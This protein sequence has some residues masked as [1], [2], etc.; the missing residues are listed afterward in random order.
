MNPDV[1][2][3]YRTRW[4]QIVLSPY[5]PYTIRT[6]WSNPTRAIKRIH[7]DVAHET[8]HS[9]ANQLGFDL[10]EWSKANKYFAANP[11]G[12]LYDDLTYAFDSRNHRWKRSPE[13]FLAE[14]SYAQ[15]MLGVKPGF[16]FS[17]WPLDKQKKTINYLSNRFDFTP[18]DTEYFLHKFSQL[19][20]KHGGKI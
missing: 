12:V 15:N 6:A 8:L 3:R 16:G 18:E 4:N 14:M 9:V 2:A 5:N 13:E 20:F 17:Q 7:G 11:N 1:P 19:G 10:S